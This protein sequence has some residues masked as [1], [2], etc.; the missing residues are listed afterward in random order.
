MY[1][2]YFILG[3]AIFWGARVSARHEWNDEYCSLR[4]TKILLGVN[5]L[6]IPLHHMAQKSCAPW[7]AQKYIVHGLDV[8]V[9]VGHLLV[10]VFLFCSGMGLYKSLKTKQDYL[11]GFV[12]RRIVPL[13]IAYYLSEYIYIAVRALMGEKMSI[14]DVIWYLSGLHMANMN[15]WYLVAII[16]FYF[17]FYLAF[18]H[19]KKD[20]TAIT[21]IFVCCF[22]YAL[23]GAAIGHQN[24]WWMRGEWWYNSIILFPIGLVFAKYEQKVTSF[25]KRAYPVL[26]PLMIVLTVFLYFLSEYVMTV[27]SYYGAR[28][29]PLTIP[30]SLGCCLVQWL[31]CIAYTAVNFLFLLKVRLGNRLLTLL[32]S[33]TLEL[34]LMHGMFVE[35]FGYDFLEEVPSI[36]YIRNVPLYIVVVF[37]CSIPATYV[38]HVVWKRATRFTKK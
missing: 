20:G 4:Q 19:C 1:I 10:A 14:T 11:K 25:F 30:R 6:L 32:G 13:I 28:N 34:Y 37:A 3:A 24:G 36:R 21:W 33:V 7:H 35:M 12:L 8:F 29:N 5:A 31:L 38:F 27:W 16:F 23:L 2:F 26:F 15:A 22:L 18:R 17:F 9:P